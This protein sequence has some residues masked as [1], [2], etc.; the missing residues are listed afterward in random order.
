M[1]SIGQEKVGCLKLESRYEFS[2]SFNPNRAMRH[3]DEQIHFD[4]KTDE[5]NYVAD[6]T[7]RIVK[8]LTG[9][10]DTI[11]FQSENY[12]NKHIRHAGFVCWAHDTTDED[13]YQKDSTFRVREHENFV[14]F[15]SVNYPG[16]FLKIDEGDDFRVRISPDDSLDYLF[17][18]REILG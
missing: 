18:F 14:Y 8:G 6:S 17:E 1:P 7:W 3:R 11:S 5:P 13:L 15:E 9:E 4:S 12:S 2:S 10:S 16:H